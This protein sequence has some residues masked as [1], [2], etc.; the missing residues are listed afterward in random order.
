MPKGENDMQRSTL[1]ETSN[2][3]PNTKMSTKDLL[4]PSYNH[5]GHRITAFFKRWERERGQNVSVLLLAFTDWLGSSSGERTAIQ[6]AGR[7]LLCPWPSRA[8]GRAAS[9]GVPG[10]PTVLTPCLAPTPSGSCS[11]T[12]WVHNLA[13]KMGLKS[14][15]P[16]FVS[17]PTMLPQNTVMLHAQKTVLSFYWLLDKNSNTTADL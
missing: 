13:C 11:H 5:Q 1:K 9:L 10:F 17:H 4:P 7:A 14:K 6:P 16:A 2:Q 8:G 3:H 12:L 15:H